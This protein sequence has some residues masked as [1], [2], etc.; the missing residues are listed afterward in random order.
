MTD[1]MENK[2]DYKKYEMIERLYSMLE[3]AVRKAY[4]DVENVFYNL[5][6]NR[7]GKIGCFRGFVGE[8][9]MV[10]TERL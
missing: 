1:T 6:I 3:T 4:D 5:W 8:S 7:N 2:I 9:P 10:K